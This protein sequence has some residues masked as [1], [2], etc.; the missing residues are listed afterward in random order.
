MGKVTHERCPKCALAGRDRAGDN[1]GVYPDGSRHCFSCGYHRSGRSLFTKRVESNG[2]ENKGVLP[3][4][5]TREVPVRAWRWLLQF[6]LSYTYW[7]EHVGWS[8][9]YSRLVFTVG[10]P[11]RFS[12]GRYIGDRD[13]RKWYIWG[14]RGEHVELI[15]PAVPYGGDSPVALVEDLISAH[16]VGQV[17]PCIP[18]FGTKVLDSTIKA[19]IDLKRPVAL[20]LDQDQY[21]LLAPKI[22]RVQTFLTHSVRYIHTEKDPKRYSIDE[23]KEILK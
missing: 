14:D 10:Q 9:H 5:F 20:W 8:E 4:D 16:K 3:F 22:N 1:L 6:G 7:K 17:T 21:T 15:R 11:T 2:Y 19:L 13:E 23:I 18:L 12:I